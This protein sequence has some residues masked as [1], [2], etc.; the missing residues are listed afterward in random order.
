MEE[1]WKRQ[2][3]QRVKIE[4]KLA[5]MRKALNKRFPGGD[6]KLEMCL[7]S[8]EAVKGLERQKWCGIKMV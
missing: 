7:S 2:M 4:P 3:R 5:K 8:R 1:E 6:R